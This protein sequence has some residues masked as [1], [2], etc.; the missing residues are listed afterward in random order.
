[1]VAR[2][3]DEPPLTTAVKERF[4]PSTEVAV[5]S[6]IAAFCVYQENNVFSFFLLFFFYGGWNDSPER[7]RGMHRDGLAASSGR[8]REVL[9]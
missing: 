7:V 4:C 3:T 8:N 1:M 6:Y 5:Q 9:L 2:E